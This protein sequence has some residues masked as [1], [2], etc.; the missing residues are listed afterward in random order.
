VPATY[1]IR[2]GDHT[3]VQC[4]AK[5]LARKDITRTVMHYW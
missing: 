2:V 4:V 1:F 3:T 5:L